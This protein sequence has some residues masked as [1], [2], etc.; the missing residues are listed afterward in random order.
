MAKKS[1]KFVFKKKEDKE[2]EKVSPT[3]LDLTPEEN[4][5]AQV[6]VE[7]NINPVDIK[8]KEIKINRVVDSDAAIINDV[9]ESTTMLQTRDVRGE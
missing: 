4:L 9:V 7:E 3:E 2:L 5:Q 1:K 6:E 8:V